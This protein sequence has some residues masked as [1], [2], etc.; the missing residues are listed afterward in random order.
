LPRWTERSDNALLL[1]P[2]FVAAAVVKEPDHM[3]AGSGKKRGTKM[4]LGES[5]AGAGLEVP[6][7]ANG[8]LFSRELERDGDR[9]RT[10]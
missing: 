7:E 4:P 6:L 3:S 5:S 10:M 8:F 2:M 9:P 1:L